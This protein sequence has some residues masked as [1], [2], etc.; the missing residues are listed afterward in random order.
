MKVRNNGNIKLASL[1]F[2]LGSSSAVLLIPAV[3]QKENLN[4]ENDI[5]GNSIQ[6]HENLAS[7]AEDTISDLKNE[8][9]DKP[10]SELK[11][12][13]KEVNSYLENP[14]KIIYANEVSESTISPEVT[15]AEVLNSS[16]ERNSTEPMIKITKEMADN[17]KLI[18]QEYYKKNN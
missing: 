13:T 14:S 6:I 15:Q 5:K 8:Y 16:T 10:I 12:K 7:K 4:Y 3:I 17:C 11:E 18:T 1:L 2:I 9:I